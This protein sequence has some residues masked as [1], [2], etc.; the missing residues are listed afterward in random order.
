MRVLRSGIYVQASVKLATQS[1]L[2][3]H[4]AYGMFDK[5]LRVLLADHSRCMLALSTR[6]TGVSEDYA[7]CPFLAGHSYLFSI[8]YDD[9]IAAINVRRVARLVF[10]TD[11]AR[12]LAGNTAEHLGIGINNNPAL[13]DCSLVG[14]DCLVTIMIHLCC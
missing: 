11:D 7:A 6:I 4:T 14:V 5:T 1:V 9:V 13:L 10:A 12:Y 2:G 8:D 3:K